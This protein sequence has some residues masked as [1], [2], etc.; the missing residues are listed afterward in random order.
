MK[1]KYTLKQKS[2]QT[3]KTT[4]VL[5]VLSLLWQN[6]WGKQPRRGGVYLGPA[7]VCP[8]S[9]QGRLGG[10]G[11][12][13]L[14]WQECVVACS[15][16]NSLRS[17]MRTQTEPALGANQTHVPTPSDPHL[18]PRQ[19][20]K[21]STASEVNVASWGQSVQTQGPVGNISRSHHK[22]LHNDLKREDS[23]WAE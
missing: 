11:S 7:Y 17:R 22:I 19:V 16:L 2:K 8:Q 1:S 21:D 12:L 14:R 10:G 6:P 3:N 23:P 15:R 18:P 9:W 5:L 13:H 20:F 4:C